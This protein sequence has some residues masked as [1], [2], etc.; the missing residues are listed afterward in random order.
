MEKQLT[1]KDNTMKIKENF[2]I[3][4]IQ[5]FSIVKSQL[6]FDFSQLKQQN[7]KNKY[8]NKRNPINN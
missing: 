5:E 2:I 6:Q 3:N 7:K 1:L 4:E 8:A